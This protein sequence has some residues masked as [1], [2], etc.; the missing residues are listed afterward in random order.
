MQ[1]GTKL[2]AEKEDESD[3]EINVVD[4]D[5][6]SGADR[7][8]SC[9]V[10]LSNAFSVKEKGEIKKTT[11]T[12]EKK[13]QRTMSIE[14]DE[15][16]DVDGVDNEE[17]FLTIGNTT[18][19]ANKSIAVVK[20]PIPAE[21]E[22]FAMS[23]S[24][25][26]EGTKHKTMSPEYGSCSDSQPEPSDL[27][28]P[29]EKKS[30]IP[31][32]IKGV[33]NG[34]KQKASR[35]RKKKMED[36][37]QGAESVE[38]E[39]SRDERVLDS[40][41][42][43]TT[44]EV[45]RGR[46]Q[47]TKQRNTRGRQKKVE[48]D[49]MQKKAAEVTGD[50]DNK[51]LSGEIEGDVEVEEESKFVRKKTQSTNRR[52]TRGRQ[53]TVED[54]QD[55]E[56]EADEAQNLEN[57]YVEDDVEV[58]EDLSDSNKDQNDLP[59]GQEQRI[60]EEELV[61]FEAVEA[62]VSNAE[63]KGKSRA[64]SLPVT[65]KQQPQKSTRKV[66]KRGVV[67]SDEELLHGGKKDDIE[68]GQAEQRGRGRKGVPNTRRQEMKVSRG[69][70]QK[71]EGNLESEVGGDS[72]D[73]N[74]VGERPAGKTRGR[75]KE[76]KVDKGRKQGSEEDLECEVGVGDNEV[77]D[78]DKGKVVSPLARKRKVAETK[79]MQRQGKSVAEGGT[80]D[81]DG[82]AKLSGRKTRAQRKKEAEQKKEDG[83]GGER[84]GG[85]EDGSAHVELSGRKTRGQS[86]KV[87]DA[88]L[89]KEDGD[90]GEREEG[91]Q[92][93]IVNSDIEDA[94]H[95]EGEDMSL[96]E[97]GKGEQDSN[98][99]VVVES[100]KAQEL[101]TVLQR[102]GRAEKTKNNNELESDGK[103]GEVVNKRGRESLR[104]Q[105]TGQSEGQGLIEEG[106]VSLNA[107]KGKKGKGKEATKISP[108]GGEKDVLDIVV[109]LDEE[110]T[111]SNET[112]QES[113]SN[114]SSVSSVV[115]SGSES[116]KKAGTKRRKHS[117]V[118]P[119]YAR[120]ASKSK[121]LKISATGNSQDSTTELELRTDAKKPRLE[122]GRKKSN[123]SDTTSKKGG[124]LASGKG[125]KAV[126]SVRKSAGGKKPVAQRNK[127]KK[128]DVTHE[129]SV[130]SAAQNDDDGDF[131]DSDEMNGE[132][133]GD[134]SVQE[135]GGVE[136]RSF[137]EVPSEAIT[138]K[139]FLKPAAKSAAALKSILKSGGSVGRTN[140]GT[141][142]IIIIIIIII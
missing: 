18:W 38:T 74:G 24:F 1:D 4:I 131:G 119:P 106:E 12:K 78:P 59:K 64:R 128:P 44:G 141:G 48:V 108:N 92:E 109:E 142:K 69:R 73:G 30:K 87:A 19:N 67:A 52:S 6:D 85:V 17:T 26:L 129:K 101:G 139:P 71:S 47:I 117:S 42:E 76:K 21:A 32:R 140:T 89:N 99:S 29:R 79:K 88:K 86:K 126:R 13:T 40:K 107:R 136:D 22:S 66:K 53:K 132:G 83:D 5:D 112:L 55:V 127:S 62:R 35:A 65:T 81:E 93:A 90:G 43:E 91:I 36:L 125:S 51:S 28:A 34:T 54:S 20:S 23:E 10:Q 80:A 70:R 50:L 9:D 68:N 118:L 45:M 11:N 61:D 111:L 25:V 102:K 37:K 16:I 134:F 56:P 113:V 58:G 7:Q 84:Q 104:D 100:V 41:Q 95:V 49:E 31:V 115:S 124:V 33:P 97:T 138:P 72:E 77:V 116:K 39:N 110:Q 120:R 122:E 96:G 98:H 137:E 2:I 75:Q 130:S 8:E 135:A 105:K 82:A 63:K 57:D 103:F 94:G 46:T 27:P 15:F 114:S 3:S 14:D 123:I 121:N 133:D 60:G